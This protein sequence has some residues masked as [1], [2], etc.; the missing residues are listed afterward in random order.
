MGNMDSNVSR[1]EM[2]V[3]ATLYLMT[4]YARTGCPR[5]AICISK[6]LQCL[7]THPDADPVIRDICA[8]MHGVWPQ[9]TAGDSGSVPAAALHSARPLQAR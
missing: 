9:A 1:P 3:A 2:L 7:A 4:H 8:G 5:L 6:H